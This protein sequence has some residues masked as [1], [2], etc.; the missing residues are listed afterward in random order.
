MN[1]RLIDMIKEKFFSN[2]N[3]LLNGAIKAE[4]YEDKK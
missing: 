4:E 1:G 3:R 2:E